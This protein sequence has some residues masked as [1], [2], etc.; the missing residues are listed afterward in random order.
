[1]A[2]TTRK[3]KAPGGEPGRANASGAKVASQ[4]SLDNVDVVDL[5]DVEDE[6][7]YEALK[8][9]NQAELIKKQNEEEA[10][11]PVRLAEFQCIIC[12][13]NP[14][15]LTVTHCGMF[16]L[17]HT[18]QDSANFPRSSLLFRM[19]LPSSTRGG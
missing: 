8:V 5:V 1:M 15:D 11:K 18:C 4:Q 3:R 19:P 6:S 16:T 9:K 17:A 12:M 14:T 7:Q 2:P 13:D 10:N